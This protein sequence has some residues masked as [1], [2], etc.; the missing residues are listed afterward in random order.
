MTEVDSIKSI[1]GALSIDIAASIQNAFTPAD[2]VPSPIGKKK[3]SP[4]L[5]LKMNPTPS[6]ANLS[7]QIN[8]NPILEPPPIHSNRH[9]DQMQQNKTIDL[10]D[11]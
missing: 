3:L 10:N 9:I 6:F 4:P 7:V 11:Q 5:M 2:T 1:N 8:D